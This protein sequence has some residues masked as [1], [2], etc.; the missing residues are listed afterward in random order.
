[1]TAPSASHVGA[2]DRW[3]RVADHLLVGDASFDAPQT[4]LVREDRKDV[5]ACA[6]DLE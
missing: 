3:C 1:M 5:L 2:I 6:V 4:K